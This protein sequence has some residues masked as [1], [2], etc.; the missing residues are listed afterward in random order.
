V[1]FIKICQFWVG[2][3]FE[4]K[5]DSKPKK[6]MEANLARGKKISKQPNK[7]FLSLCDSGQDNRSNF[8][9]FRKGVVILN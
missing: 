2:A 6:L 1:F 8:V 4:A 9:E 3:P 7:R 5:I